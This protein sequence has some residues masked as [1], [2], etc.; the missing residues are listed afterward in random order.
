MRRRRAAP[1]AP[2]ELERI[3]RASA[4]PAVAFLLL[5]PLGLLHLS[6][7]RRANL[8]AYS[9]I[10]GPLDALGAA[11]PWLLAAFLAGALLWSIGR[12][13][14][15]RIPWRAGLLLSAGEGILWGLLLGP[16]LQVAL[17]LVALPAGPLHLALDGQHLHGTLAIAAGAGLYEE[18]IFRALLL[19]ALAALFLGLFQLHAE[20]PLDTFLPYGLA[21]L[22]SA[23]VFAAAHALGDPR[24]LEGPVFVYR[25]LAGVLLGLLYRARGLAVVAYAHATYDAVVIFW[26]DPA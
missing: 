24:A 18:L 19:H 4:D 20:R 15:R 22:G 6:G 5:L 23:L 7:R 21:I 9:W 1:A 3:R 14:R 17:Q 12:I 25:F 2:S 10:E 8:A 16:L 13:Q 26:T 11:A